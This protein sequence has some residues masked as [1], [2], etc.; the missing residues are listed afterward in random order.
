MVF[1]ASKTLSFLAFT[2][3]CQ[4]SHRAW[5]RS[6]ANTIAARTVLFRYSSSWMGRVF[7]CGFEPLKSVLF[8]SL[9]ATPGKLSVCS[10]ALAS[11]DAKTGVQLFICLNGQNPFHFE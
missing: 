5:I 1:P 11:G 3:T 2:T 6:L 9:K 8:S 10:P 4:E 7:L